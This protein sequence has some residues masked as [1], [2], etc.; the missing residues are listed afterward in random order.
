MKNDTSGLDS[1][2]HRRRP[3]AYFSLA[4]SARLGLLGRAQQTL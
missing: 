4:L 2:S 3:W 1:V